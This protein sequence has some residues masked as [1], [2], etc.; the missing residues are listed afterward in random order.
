L[1]PQHARTLQRNPSATR[2]NNTK[3]LLK[4]AT[5]PVSMSNA[6]P[7]IRKKHRLIILPYTY[8]AL[9]TYFQIAISHFLNNFTPFKQKAC[10]P[11]LQSA[12]S[13]VIQKVSFCNVPHS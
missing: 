6:V 3:C 8:P 4:R 9:A 13:T 12:V 5:T 2:P 1:F 10:E 11:S 7:S